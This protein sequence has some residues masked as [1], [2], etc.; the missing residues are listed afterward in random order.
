MQ[1]SLPASGIPG[2]PQPHRLWDP[3]GRTRTMCIIPATPSLY[4]QARS[5]AQVD[6]LINRDLISK[7][8]FDS[9]YYKKIRRRFQ[10]RHNFIEQAAM[11]PRIV[12]SRFLLRLGVFIRSLAIMAMRPDDLVEFSRQAYTKPRELRYWSSEEMVA[13]GLTPSEKTLLENIPLKKGRRLLLGLGGGR[14]AI[15]LAK[16]GFAV[17]GVDFVPEMSKRAQENAARHG[18]NIEVLIQ[19]VS[20]LEVPAGSFDLA[21]LSN[22]MYSCVPIRTRRVEM[23]R[24]IHQALRPGGYFIC[25]FHWEKRVGFS[26]KVELARKI[27]AYLTL[28]NLSYEPGD[29]LWLNSEFIHA[30]SSETELMSEFAECGFRAQH[31]HIPESGVDGWAVL[32]PR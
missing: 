31:L 22:S 14:E 13:G 11:R 3:A 23:L 1:A 30:F 4:Y 19:E 7:W 25:S 8:L 10:A 9:N 26:A 15:H 28:G 20:Q 16:L 27:F 2:V 17:T 6:L 18:V 32:G 24:R 21:W 5:L 12:L 29:K